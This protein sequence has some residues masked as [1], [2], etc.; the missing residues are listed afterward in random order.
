MISNQGR[1]YRGIN[2]TGPPSYRGSNMCNYSPLTRLPYLKKDPERILIQ[3]PLGTSYASSE[4]KK[5]LRVIFGVSRQGYVH[6]DAPRKKPL[7]K[8]QRGATPVLLPSISML[9][10]Q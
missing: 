9:H 5:A 7:L 10:F 6:D 4:C 8:R 2:D 1:N 3:G